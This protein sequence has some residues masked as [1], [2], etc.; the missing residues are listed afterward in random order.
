MRCPLSQVDFKS[1]ELKSSRHGDKQGE[2]WGK[3]TT[4]Q[5]PGHSDPDVAVQPETGNL[6]SVYNTRLTLCLVTSRLLLVHLL[7]KLSFHLTLDNTETQ[8]D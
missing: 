1:G 6:S 4:L 5:L 2:S 8:G 7:L 3:D